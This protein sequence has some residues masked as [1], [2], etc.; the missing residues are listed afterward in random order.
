M[1]LSHNSRPTNRIARPF[2]HNITTLFN[3]RISIISCLSVHFLFFL[4]FFFSTVFV[5]LFWV[6][7]REY[8]SPSS[9]WGLMQLRWLCNPRCN[10]RYRVILCYAIF[11]F[12][13]LNNFQNPWSR[14]GLIVSN[15]VVFDIYLWIWN[16]SE[17]S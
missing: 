5:V 12:V 17:K 4:P 13:F 8:L 7:A 9:T 15:W 6:V 10:S 11:L 2:S 1:F 14:A 16:I 3:T